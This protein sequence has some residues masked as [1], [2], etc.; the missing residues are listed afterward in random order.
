MASPSSQLNAVTCLCW[1]GRNLALQPLDSSTLS[2]DP[3]EKKKAKRKEKDL[4]ARRASHPVDF[5]VPVY[6]CL[7]PPSPQ[8]GREKKCAWLVTAQE[9]TCA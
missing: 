6:F 1:R 8:V 3:E 7:S 9:A 4:V 5:S 2:R